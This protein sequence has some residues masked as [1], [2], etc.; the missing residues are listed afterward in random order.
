MMVVE[1]IMACIA[2]YVMSRADPVASPVGGNPLPGRHYL[3]GDLMSKDDRSPS[4]PVP[5]HDI[6]AADAAG[7]DAKKQFPRPRHRHG[8]FFDPDVSTAE[9]PCDL[10]AIILVNRHL[11]VK[12]CII[13]SLLTSLCQ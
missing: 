10:H 8:H 2:G 11:I 9:I 13:K 3:A 7:P 1:T 4:R 12:D 6:A 5:V